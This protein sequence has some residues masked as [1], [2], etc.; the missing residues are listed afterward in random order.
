LALVAER[1]RWP[2]VAELMALEG[3][4]G[5]W[6]RLLLQGRELDLE[7]LLAEQGV[8]SGA[9]LTSIRIALAAEGWKIQANEDGLTSS[10]DEDEAAWEQTHPAAKR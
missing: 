7:K 2:P 8:G 1:L 3:F 6:E 4:D 9:E 10:S 5:P